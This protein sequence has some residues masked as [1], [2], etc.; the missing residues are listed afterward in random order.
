MTAPIVAITSPAD[1]ASTSSTQIE[2]TGTA[3]DL[4]LQSV[5]VNGV[6]ATIAGSSFTASASLIVGANTVSVTARDYAGNETTQTISV[7]V[8]GW[9]P[10]TAIGL[11]LADSLWICEQLQ[12]HG[13]WFRSL[14]LTFRTLSSNGVTAAI[15]GETFTADVTLTGSEGG[16]AELR[17]RATDQA[18]NWTEKSIWVRIDTLAPQVTITTPYDGIITT[19][20]QLTVQGG[21][22]DTAIKE[23]T[24]NG[25]QASIAGSFYTAEVTLTSGINTIEVIATD[26]AGNTA[27]T[28]RVVDYRPDSEMPQ[29]AIVSPANEAVVGSRSV[30]VT[31]TIID[32][33]I[34][35]VEVND[36]TATITGTTFTVSVP[37]DEGWNELTARAV[38]LVGNERTTSIW[39]VVDTYRPILTIDAPLDGSFLQDLQVPVS[40]YV[41]DIH[42]SE[43]T[44][45]DTPAIVQDESYSATVDLVQ[46]ENEVLVRASDEAW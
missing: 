43:V 2:V 21:V 32:N 34:D 37:C 30:V 19:Q 8:E 46:G 36:I 40:G 29:I 18:G 10:S 16:L 44:V 33:D 39:A 41:Y 45:N 17:A 26:L 7:T 1:G 24:V 13:Y 11:H 31:G 27:Q 15:N 14:I 12:R 3:T 35:F 42:L 5:T 38:D 28:Q 9:W 23:V 6:S 22:Y 4:H 20:L 25:I